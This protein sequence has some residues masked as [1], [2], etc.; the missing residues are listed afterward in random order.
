[1]VTFALVALSEVVLTVVGAVSK[2]T[3]FER[4]ITMRD[5][6]FKLNTVSK[7]KS[8]ENNT[9]GYNERLQLKVNHTLKEICVKQSVNLCHVVVRLFLIANISI[10]TT[11]FRFWSYALVR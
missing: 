11:A 5:S 8:V 10:F 3:A 9:R 1:M 7:R 2:T 6:D 4:D